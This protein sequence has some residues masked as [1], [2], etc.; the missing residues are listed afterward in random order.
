MGT[1]IVAATERAPVKPGQA[2]VPEFVK[3]F[4]V[5]FFLFCMVLAPLKT[6][7]AVSIKARRSRVFCRVVAGLSCLSMP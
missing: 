2:P 3:W 7:A 4:L 1:L 5:A 6:R